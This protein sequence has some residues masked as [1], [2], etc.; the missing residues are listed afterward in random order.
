MKKR[1]RVKKK[2]IRRTMVL[3]IAG[4]IVAA[5]ILAVF[6]TVS[7]FVYNRYFAEKPTVEYDKINV[8]KPEISKEYLTLNP[9][10]RSGKKLKKVKRNKNNYEEMG[11]KN[12]SKFP[13]S[14]NCQ[15]RNYI[16]CKRIS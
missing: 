3:V 4:G 8:S 13:G 2:Q 15:L 7:G 10:S 11:N 6:M 14:R 9:N 16:F 5:G 1:T 12:C